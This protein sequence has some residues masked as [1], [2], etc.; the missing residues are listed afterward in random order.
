VPSLY[1]A[2][3]FLHVTGAIVW[4]GGGAMHLALMGLAYRSGTPEDRVR[5]L[6]YDDR[7]GLP[8]YIPALLVVLGAGIGLV[9]DG[10]WSWSDGW[11]IAGLVIFGLAVALGVAFFLPQGA[12][13]KGVV[14]DRGAA[15]DE[16]QALVRR[17]E[18]V[19]LADLALVLAAVFVMTTKPGV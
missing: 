6:D 1:E 5:L 3:L 18:L 19:A 15:S 2:L 7:L 8:L 16:A 17:I 4:I 13:L 14:K 12:K 11:I 9:L 10:P